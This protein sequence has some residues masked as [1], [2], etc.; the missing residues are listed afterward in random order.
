MQCEE[1][2]VQL[3]EALDR[4][5]SLTAAEALAHQRA[6]P[7]C[8]Q[9]ASLY[10]SIA[11][12][13]SQTSL[14]A[15]SD[16]LS[17]RVLTEVRRPATLPFSPR[18]RTALVLAAAATLLVAVVGVRLMGRGEFAPA[19]GQQV[20]GKSDEP[21][22]KRRQTPSPQQGVNAPSDRVAVATKQSEPK[23]GSEIVPS[24]SDT[25]AMPAAEWAQH[26]ADGLQPVTR[27]TLGAAT[28]F[29]QVW[30]VGQKRPPS[31]Q[32]PRS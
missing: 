3:N 27:P 24:F 6:C 26:V 5:S 31:A 12:E 14:P 30:G 32:G 1:F 19:V 22:A 9:R 15:L 20:A 23:P 17:Q 21:V 8:R 2:E 7:A 18:R 10:A 16:D 11:R 13:L 4:R 28:G 25:A 29:L